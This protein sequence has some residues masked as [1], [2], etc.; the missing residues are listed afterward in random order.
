MT[1]AGGGGGGVKTDSLY[2]AAA[3]AAAA[4]KAN[5]PDKMSAGVRTHQEKTRRK[6]SNSE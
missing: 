4:V 6:R 3:A 1:A 2:R 5:A